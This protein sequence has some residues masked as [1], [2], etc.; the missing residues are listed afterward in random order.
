MPIRT[1]TGVAVTNLLDAANDYITT[2]ISLYQD[3][4]I[5]GGSFEWTGANNLLLQIVNTNNH[6]VTWGV[7]GAAVEALGNFMRLWPPGKEAALGYAV[8]FTIT[9]GGTQ[10]GVGTLGN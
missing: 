5:A 10:V 7:L 6:Q 2:H 8:Y 1:I 3:S 4:N 9:D